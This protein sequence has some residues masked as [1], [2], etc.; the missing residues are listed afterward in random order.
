M[1][2]EVDDKGKK[3]DRREILLEMKREG[4]SWHVS[5]F[6]PIAEALAALEKTRQAEKYES[7][8]REESDAYRKNVRISELRAQAISLYGP[9]PFIVGQVENR[10]DRR[11]QKLGIE[12][13]IRDAGGQIIAQDTYHPVVASSIS[14]DEKPLDAGE[15][16]KI[17]YQIDKVP[18]NWRDTRRVSAEIVTL[19]LAPPEE[20]SA[21]A[22][23]AK[24]KI[25]SASGRSG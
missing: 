22:K 17:S 12:F 19:L 11:I 3:K 1:L 23:E 8:M 15:K 5:Q 16:R 21:D 10:G 13:T 14:N 2:L 9:A 4:D 18:E 20:E 24:K 7:Q 6:Q 25:R